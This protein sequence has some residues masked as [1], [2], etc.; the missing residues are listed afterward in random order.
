MLVE[1]QIEQSMPG[2]MKSFQFGNNLQC[3]ENLFIRINELSNKI[4]GRIFE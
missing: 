3:Q 4:G 1:K 2:L